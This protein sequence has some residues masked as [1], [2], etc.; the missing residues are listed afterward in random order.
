MSKQLN[1]TQRA[2]RAAGGPSAVARA[3]NKA[4]STITA[5]GHKNQ[6]EPDCIIELCTMTKGAFQP[7]QLCPEVFDESHN[8][9]REF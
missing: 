2:I 8:V 4:P 5:W 9:E 6:A 7:F 1:I 3:F